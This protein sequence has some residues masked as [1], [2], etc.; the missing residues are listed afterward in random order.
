MWVEVVCA[1]VLLY[2]LVSG[3]RNGLV[4]ELCSTVGFVVG[5]VAAWYLHDKY[6]LNTWWTLLFCV[7]VPIVL[8]FVASLVSV[9]LNSIFLI[10][11]LN[12]LLGAVVGCVK[13][14]LLIGFI[15]LLTDYIK[16]WK[17]LLP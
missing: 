8:G 2:G 7:A 14:G 5:C 16:E 12:R 6:N 1:L 15:L 9:V 4:K 17:S 3:W 13:Y 10:G 11:T